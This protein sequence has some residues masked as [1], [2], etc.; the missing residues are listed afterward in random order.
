MFHVVFTLALVDI[1]NAPKFKTCLYTV[2]LR[3]MLGKG[4]I[5]ASFLNILIKLHF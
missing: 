1:K 2:L 4:I 5:K 3:L